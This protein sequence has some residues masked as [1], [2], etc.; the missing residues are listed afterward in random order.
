MK[1][2]NDKAY[3]YE[4]AHVPSTTVTIYEHENSFSA[5]IGYK[6][7]PKGYVCSMPKD[8]MNLDEFVNFVDSVLTGTDFFRGTYMKMVGKIN[9]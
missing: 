8:K 3:V 7:Q 9:E 1:K 6:T 2:L 5:Y 4:V